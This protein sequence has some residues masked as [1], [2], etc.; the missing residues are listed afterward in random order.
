MSDLSIHFSKYL[1][2]LIIITACVSAENLYAFN[3]DLTP[4]VFTF[5]GG[6]MWTSGGNTQTLDL[7]NEITKTYIASHSQN[8]AANFEFF[9]GIQETLPKSLLGQLGLV[10]AKA[11]N[12]QLSGDIW[13]DADPEFNNY[14]YHYNVNHFHLALQGKLLANCRWPV[15][16]WISAS[17][18]LGFN[19]AQNFTNTPKIFEALPNSNFSNSTTISFVYT[20]GVGIQY[21]M[22]QNWQIGVGYE[23]ADWGRSQ[24]GKAAGQTTNNRLTRNHLY[25]NSLL[26]NLTYDT[27]DML[28][29]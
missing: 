9:V 6:P 2:F 29:T 19:R 21:R 26:I 7:A 16:P 27:E 1:K 11:T 10:L 3:I 28:Q 25:T 24:L 5:S 17:A 8:A 23:F 22:I 4:T 12:P 15:A 18:G 13:D 20:I 14:V